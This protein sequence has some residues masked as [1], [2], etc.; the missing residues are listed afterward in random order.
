MP[1]AKRRCLTDFLVRPSCRASS[2][3]DSV[4]ESNSRSSASV[5]GSRCRCT[6]DGD[7]GLTSEPCIFNV[8]Q[9]PSELNFANTL[10]NGDQSNKRLSGADKWQPNETIF[11]FCFPHRRESPIKSTGFGVFPAKP[12]PFILC[13]GLHKTRRVFG[14]ADAEW[15]NYRQMVF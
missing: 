9:L 15:K 11:Q 1:L 3:F 8:G 10:L 2:E 13:N 6:R 5:H 14:H 4:R 12:S 7:I